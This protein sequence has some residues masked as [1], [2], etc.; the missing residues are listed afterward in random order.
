MANPEHVAIFKKGK[1]VWNQWRKDNPHILPDLRDINIRSVDLSGTYL[2]E[3]YIPVDVGGENINLSGT[4]LAGANIRNAQLQGAW[5]NGA[6]LHKAKLRDADLTGAHLNSADLREADLRGALLQETI[7]QAADLRGASLV[8]ATLY[9]A[10]LDSAN[11]VGADLSGAV[12]S[13]ADLQYARLVNTNLEGAD[14]TNCHIYGISAWDIKLNQ[15]TK[16]RN[17]TI[18]PHDESA[19]SVD[20]I[21]VAQFIYLLLNNEEIRDVIDTIAKNAVL[22]LGRFTEERKKVLD[23]IRDELRKQN[24]LPILFDFAKPT[25]RDITETIS[26]LAHISRFIIADLTDAKSI[27]QE[28]QAIVPNLPSVPVQPLLAANATE[29]AM[30]EHFKRYPWV[31]PVYHY[32]DI[33]MLVAALDEQV[34]KPAVSKAQEVSPR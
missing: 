33:A 18:T 25:S 10:Y 17:L 9:D 16:Q 28:L 5:L 24:W 29:Y 14:L 12:L 11:L 20:Q 4:N 22:I 19:I 26:T 30:F 21:K 8:N 13:G 1:A 6:K 7:L 23:V 32:N 3:R 15:N 31:L 34:I 2:I 27:P